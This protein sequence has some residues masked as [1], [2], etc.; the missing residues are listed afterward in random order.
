MWSYFCWCGF[1]TNDRFL[2]SDRWVALIYSYG[3]VIYL[4]AIFLC[5]SLVNVMHLT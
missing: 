2:T 3:F 5:E 4:V 1:T